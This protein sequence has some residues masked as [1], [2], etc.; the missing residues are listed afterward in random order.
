MYKRDTF[1]ECGGFLDELWPGEDVELDY[2]LKKKGY[3]LIC[4][5]GAVVYHYR[6]KKLAVFLA[7]MYR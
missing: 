4:N 6:P 7:M 3:H 5:P 1:L 2:R